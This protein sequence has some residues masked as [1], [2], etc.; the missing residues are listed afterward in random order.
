L[1]I[2]WPFDDGSEQ[3]WWPIFVLGVSVSILFSVS[4]WLLVSFRRRSSTNETEG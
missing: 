1:A 4:F 3:N 2:G